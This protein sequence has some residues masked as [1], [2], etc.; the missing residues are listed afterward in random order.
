MLQGLEALNQRR[1]GLFWRNLSMSDKRRGVKMSIKA[2]FPY[3]TLDQ[4]DE[5]LGSIKVLF[6]PS[7]LEADVHLMPKEEPEKS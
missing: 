7:I 3:I 1:Y 5:L 6:K 2:E 4:A